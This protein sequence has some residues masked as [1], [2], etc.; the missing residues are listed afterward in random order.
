MD[1]FTIDI[2]FITKICDLN[3][4]YPNFVGNIRILPKIL[5][6]TRKQSEVDRIPLEICI[7]AIDRF[8]FVTY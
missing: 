8:Q 6:R 5:D 3:R 2:R 4:K 7:F 1:N